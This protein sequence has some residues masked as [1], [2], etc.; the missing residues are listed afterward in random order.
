[1]SK[2]HKIVLLVWTISLL[3]IS[4]ALVSG[5]GVSVFQL[6]AVLTLT[7]GLGYAIL[8]LYF[9]PYLNARDRRHPNASAIFVINLFLGWTLLGWVGALA[10]S[11]TKS[12]AA[13]I[14]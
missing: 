2:T 4:F 3:I 1:M 9:L 5:G 14:S 6:L 10:W 7:I 12:D 8:S 13:T 11:Y